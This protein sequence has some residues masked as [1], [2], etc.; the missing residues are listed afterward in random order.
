MLLV[1]VTLNY[2][3]QPQRL[4]D[5]LWG[6][7]SFGHGCSG[8]CMMSPRSSFRSNIRKVNCSPSCPVSCT[9]CLWNR[10]VYFFSSSHVVKTLNVTQKQW[11][12]CLIPT[13]RRDRL[14]VRLISAEIVQSVIIGWRRTHSDTGV[15]KRWQCTCGKTLHFWAL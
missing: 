15:M 11:I 8:W 13:R 2:S 6:V 5:H 12:L 1:L 14:V 9:D 7:S 4:V 10:L 3:W